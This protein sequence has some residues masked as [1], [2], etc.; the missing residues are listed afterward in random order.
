M[1]RV[2]PEQASLVTR[3]LVHATFP[4]SVPSIIAH[5]VLPEAELKGTSVGRAYVHL[6]PVAPTDNWHEYKKIAKDPLKATAYVWIKKEVF[7]RQPC[8]MTTG[9]AIL[10]NSIHPS[11]IEAVGIWSDG[12]PGSGGSLRMIYHSEAGNLP[13]TDFRPISNAATTVV[14]RMGLDVKAEALPVAEGVANMLCRNCHARID[15]HWLQ[16]PRC[17]VGFTY[18]GRTTFVGAKQLV[19][20]T[21]PRSAKENPRYARI[22]AFGPKRSG[23]RSKISTL[24]KYARHLYEHITK[25]ETND[26]YREEQAAKGRTCFADRNLVGSWTSKDL[27]RNPYTPCSKQFVFNNSD[28]L[29]LAAAYC[30]RNAKGDATGP[31]DRL[32][33]ERRRQTVEVINMCELSVGKMGELCSQDTDEAIRQIRENCPK[34][35]ISK[36]EAMTLSD[37]KPAVDWSNL[38]QALLNARGLLDICEVA[39]IAD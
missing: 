18:Q 10:T 16:C 33:Y 2:M 19:A 7:E 14:Q 26:L 34:A 31:T 38:T 39:E 35:E 1:M 37:G 8:Y 27:L 30:M 29:C 15:T 21:L 5:G 28:A 20:V 32:N 3:N 36:L 13:V 25:W 9:H 17:H 6:V 11:L 22:M 4:Q 12:E 23:Q 24:C